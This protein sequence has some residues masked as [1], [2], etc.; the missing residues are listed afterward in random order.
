VQHI[1]AA[2][3]HLI[4]MVS[5]MLDLAKLEA[6]KVALEPIALRI[7]DVARQSLTTLQASAQAKMISAEVR[8]EP[9]ERIVSADPIKLARIMNNLLS[10]AIK[11]TPE[12]GQITI[13]VGPEPSGMCLRVADTGLGIPVD[14]LP[15][16]FEKFHQVHTRGTANERGTG[17]GLAIVRQLVELHGGTIEIT[18][19]MQRGSTFSVHLP[20]HAEGIACS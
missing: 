20:T 10:N 11:F 17:L 13:T 2:A 18:S 5:N 8:V 9:G 6:G 12:G 16:L 7:S 1:D 4:A 15:R 19:A 3:R 14:A